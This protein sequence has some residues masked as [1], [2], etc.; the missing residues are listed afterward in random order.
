MTEDCIK[1]FG[2]N[3]INEFKYP[4]QKKPKEVTKV[5]DPINRICI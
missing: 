1:I 5:C 3:F 4:D 2:Q